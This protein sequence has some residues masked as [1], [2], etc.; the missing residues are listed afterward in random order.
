MAKKDKIIN[1][2]CRVLVVCQGIQ[3]I[4]SIINLI[5]CFITGSTYLFPTCNPSWFIPQYY[6]SN[7]Q[8]LWN[9]IILALFIGVTVFLYVKS[10]KYLLGDSVKPNQ[11]VALNGIWV[12]L[13]LLS[14]MMFF[15]F[16]LVGRSGDVPYWSPANWYIS[17]AVYFTYMLVILIKYNYSDE[18]KNNLQV[19]TYKQV[20]RYAI[21]NCQIAAFTLI[22]DYWM[23]YFADMP[24]SNPNGHD[25]IEFD[26]LL[27]SIFIMINIVLFIIT[28]V[29]YFD[30]KK[31][32]KDTPPC[33][34]FLLKIS[35]LQ[36]AAIIIEVV[37]ILLSAFVLF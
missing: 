30:V 34:H 3:I 5:Y 33:K 31:E 20:K 28:T 19:T 12:M 36:I 35:L 23:H 14:Y 21:S 8:G 15:A 25:V 13:C 9:A 29:F 2:L 17:I 37:G 1:K 16:H 6:L 27:S 4:S 10:S 24:L 18:F 11:I 7:G 32:G 26:I 22:L